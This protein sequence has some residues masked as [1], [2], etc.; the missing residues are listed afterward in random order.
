MY[1]NERCYVGARCEAVAEA[2]EGHVVT[3]PMTT[4]PFFERT[5]LGASEPVAVHRQRGKYSRRSAVPV[6][7][8]V[9]RSER[10]VQ[11]R[12]PQSDVW[13]GLEPIPCV[14]LR[15]YQLHP[16]VDVV[17][18]RGIDEIA[19]RIV[20]QRACG[21]VPTRAE[22]APTCKD[23]VMDRFQKFGRPL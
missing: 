2:P 23:A 10:H 9:N 14:H 12:R 13:C 8:G 4:P 16:F 6:L 21:P 22:I 15:T 18:W 5:E 19:C 17:L 11:P 1:P 3:L 7:K 20:S